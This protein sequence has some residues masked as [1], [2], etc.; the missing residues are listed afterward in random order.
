MTIDTGDHVKHGPTG[1]TWVVAFVDGDRLFWCG[2]PEGSALLSDCELTKKATAADR[3]KL[4][5]SMR[6][7]EGVRARYA[8]RVLSD[9]VM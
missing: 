1:E 7:G 9:G 3:H 4:L 8:E 6:G 5:L 2:W